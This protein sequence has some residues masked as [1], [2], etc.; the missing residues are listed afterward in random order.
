MKELVSRIGVAETKLRDLL[1]ELVIEMNFNN[2]VE[3]DRETLTAERVWKWVD[4]LSDMDK[5]CYYV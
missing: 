5:F 2:E 1:S 4:A 3:F